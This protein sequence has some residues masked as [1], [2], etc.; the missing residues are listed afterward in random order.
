MAEESVEAWQALLWRALAILDSTFGA[1]AAAPA[2]SFGGGTV[3]MLRYRHRVSNDLEIFVP[4]AQWLAYLSPGFNQTAAALAPDYVEN[5]RSL[6]LYF[7]EGEINFVA[8]AGLTA[9][10]WS[11]E[12]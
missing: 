9:Q 8:S 7:P 12:A 10:P 2:W 3:L 5:A 6:K 1:R 4:E 11:L